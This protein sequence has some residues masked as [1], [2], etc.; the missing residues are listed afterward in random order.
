M[1]TQIRICL[2][3][4]FKANFLIFRSAAA[5]RPHLPLVRPAAERKNGRKPTTVRRQRMKEGLVLMGLL[6][7][8]RQ[9][10]LSQVVRFY[11]LTEDSGGKSGNLD[12]TLG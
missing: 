2:T 1:K 6:D 11:S 3:V 10:C 5:E 12:V 9:A 8:Q 4:E 7:P